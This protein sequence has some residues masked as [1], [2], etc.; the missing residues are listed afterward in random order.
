M[1]HREVNAIGDRLQLRQ[2]TKRICV[3][4]RGTAV[5]EQNKAR[6]PKSSRSHL[7]TDTAA[8]ETVSESSSEYSLKASIRL[9]KFW[10][11]ETKGK[12]LRKRT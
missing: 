3:L 1:T 11:P 2:K 8:I 10:A 12:C 7:F 4:I 6:N 5:R 9:M